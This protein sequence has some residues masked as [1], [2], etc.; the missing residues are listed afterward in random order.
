ML[1]V[2]PKTVLKSWAEFMFFVTYH[3]EKLHDPVETIFKPFY[4]RS[5]LFPLVTATKDPI[6]YGPFNSLVLANTCVVF[7]YVL[8]GVHK[9]TTRSMLQANC[10]PNLLN[11]QS[12]HNMSNLSISFVSLSRHFYSTLTTY[13]P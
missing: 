2:S 12:F 10:I 7:K 13:L 8:D 3:K 4:I 9:S 6:C 1:G 5:R 11:Y